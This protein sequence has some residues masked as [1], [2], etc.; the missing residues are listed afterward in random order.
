MS[1]SKTKPKIFILTLL[2]LTVC[3][4]LCG[5]AQI[6]FVTYHNDDGTIV[7]YV[8]L[9]IDEQ[10][11]IEHNENPQQ[12]SIEIPSNCYAEAK[13]LLDNFHLKFSTQYNNKLLSNEE[14]TTYYNGVE[15]VQQDYLNGKYAIGFKYK[16]SEIYKKYYEV[17]NNSTFNNNPKRVKKLFYT[18]TYYYGTANYG[19][20]SI[21]NSIYTYYTNSRFVAISP[22]EANLTYTYSVS[23]RRF[24]SDANKIQ[25][26]SNGNYLHTWNISPEEPAKQ[27]HFYTISA[28]KSIWILICIGIS[29]ICCLGLGAVGIIKHSKLKQPK[30][31]DNNSIIVN[32]SNK[33][34]T[35]INQNQT[36]Q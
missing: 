1:K 13:K 7:E 34:L 36:E 22:Q 28:N 16:N 29:L 6:N 8:Y 20:Y 11:L 9:D 18:K 35:T 21:F 4:C 27:I 15:I 26:D 33:D 10:R 3:F 5:C 30:T 2:L 17:L 23:S 19:D 32:N 14:Y 24:H 25:L 31:L 12:I